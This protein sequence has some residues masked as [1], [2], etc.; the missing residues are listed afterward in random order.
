MNTQDLSRLSDEQL[1]QI[2]SRRED[3]PA[4]RRAATVLFGRYHGRIYRWAR[5]YVDHHEEALDL[6]QDIMLSA[7]NHLPS[8]QSRS[9]FYAWL[10]VITRNRCLN[11]LRRPRLLVADEAA[12]DALPAEHGNPGRQLEEKLG[13]SEVLDLIE[14]HLDPVEQNAIY[15]RCF[16]RLSVDTITRTLKI[17]GS[18]GARSVL[19]RARHK[20]RR[21]LE[22]RQQRMH[23]SSRLSDRQ[24]SR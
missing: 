15:L 2:A 17:S 22:E 23:R 10:F 9:R 20:L 13:E 18:T 8:Y 7:W 24:G 6:A 14:T 21:A 3:D 11:A 12:V 16:E 1:A 5:R 19:Q 4:A